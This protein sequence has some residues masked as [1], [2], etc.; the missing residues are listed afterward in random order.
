[1]SGK[2]SESVPGAG[3]GGHKTP[4]R[5]IDLTS[6]KA[7][8]ANSRTD[9][10]EDIA[11]NWQWV[12]DALVVGVDGQPS[13]KQQLDDAVAKVLKSW[14]GATAD[15]F[16]AQAKKI[17]QNIANGAPYAERTSSVLKHTAKSLAYYKKQLDAVNPPND[18]ERGKD[19]LGDGLERSD[20]GLKA[21][22]AAGASTEEALANNSGKLSLDKER[23]LEAA[24]IMETLGATYVRNARAIGTPPRTPNPQDVVEEPSFSEPPPVAI[25]PLPTVV[26]KPRPSSVSTGRGGTSKGPGAVAPLAP[27][28]DSGIIGGAQKPVKPGAPPVGTVIDGISTNPA[29]SGSSHVPG[30][31]TGAGGGAGTGG[32]LP[33]LPGAGSSIGSG[34]RAGGG[35]PGATRLPGMPGGGITGKPAP[36]RSGMPGAPGGAGSGR[37]G[38]A[39]GRGA[40]A[41]GR[42]GMAAGPGSGASAR[43][44]AAGGGGATGGLARQRGGT[45]GS[46]SKNGA[47]PT[48][49]GGSGLH[50]SRGGTMAGQ[51]TGRGAGPTAGMPGTRGA[52]EREK[53]REGE[54]PD[55][56]VEDEETWDPRRDV[57]PRVID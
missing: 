36:G 27:P 32:S 47:A 21:D 52:S 6:L 39:A 42:G 8:V 15:A 46:P 5:A 48:A 35:R 17:S 24:I 38:S 40:G 30:G 13:I 22:F 1:M 56:L 37:S 12:H 51:G 14:E 29:P 57:A 19:K 50:R 25:M 55:Y 54:R 49:Q 7:M 9:V 11:E 31:G 16:A 53:R 41:V 3:P 23:Q 45:V 26:T 34:R 10:L 20:K 4:F 33:G 43:S 18:W 28:R 44:G 2:Y